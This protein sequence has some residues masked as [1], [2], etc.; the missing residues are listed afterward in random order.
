MSALRVLAPF[1]GVLLRMMC[2]ACWGLARP[3]TLSSGFYA[4]TLRL[5]TSCAPQIEHPRT[6][7][8][9]RVNLVG[10]TVR[11]IDVPEQCLAWTIPILYEV[12][13]GWLPL[14]DC[15]NTAWFYLRARARSIRAGPELQLV[16]EPSGITLPHFHGRLFFRA[17]KTLVIKSCRTTFILKL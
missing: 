16:L 9:R 5:V 3:V 15:I 10:E 17:S 6:C 11:E 4:I 14:I 8:N 7:P 1:S 12:S 13:P 2:A